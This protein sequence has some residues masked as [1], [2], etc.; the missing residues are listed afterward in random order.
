MR[1]AG[2]IAQVGDD[3]GQ[4]RGDDSEQGSEQPTVVGAGDAAPS[5]A[6]RISKG[7]AIGRYVVLELIGHGGMGR[8]YKAYDPK[9]KREVALKL[10]RTNDAEMEQRAI[11]EAQ[12]MASLS[13]PNVVPVYDVDRADT[14]IY[15]AMEFIPGQT[16][17]A[18]LKTV[19]PSQR[20][21]AA[22]LDI[23][24]QVGRGLAAAHQAD[25]VHRDLKPSNVVLGD[26]GRARVM[27]FGLAR[28]GGVE[29]DTGDFSGESID[30]TGPLTRMGTVLGTPP[31]MPPEQHRA[32]AV[33]TRSDQFA[34]CVV[35]YEALFG[36]RPF[37]ADKLEALAQLKERGLSQWPT[38]PPVPAWLAKAIRKGLSPR[39][40]GRFPS[41]DA[42][43][44]AIDR[45]SGSKV[46]RGPV[47]LAGLAASVG[48]G[49]LAW[50]QAA[51]PK[52][53]DPCT[54]AAEM[55]AGLWN[56]DER[57][58]VTTRLE[59]AALPF[60]ADTASRV[61][62]MLDAYS[63]S[64]AAGRYDACAATQIRHEQSEALMDRRFACLERA[65][66]ALRST[67]HELSTP[68]DVTVVRNAIRTVLGLPKLQHC[69]DPARLLAA[70][71][72][73]EDPAVAA[74]VSAIE[75]R[76]EE[77]RVKRR[78]GH[79]DQ[80]LADARELS[81][82]AERVAYEPVRAEAL[83]LLGHL[84]SKSGE[85]APA[86]ESLQR[87]YHAAIVSGHD[88][89]AAD[90]AAELTFVVGGLMQDHEGAR[91]H[92][93]DSRA[94]AEKVGTDEARARHENIHATLLQQ[95]GHYKEA[96]RRFET[97]LK[98][99]EATS[100]PGSLPIANALNNLANVFMDQGQPERAVTL[101][102]RAVSI[103]ENLYGPEHVTVGAFVNNLANAKAGQ[104]L[105]DEGWPLYERALSIFE[106]TY[107]PQHPDV[108]GFNVNMA[109]TAWRRGRLDEA[110]ARYAKALAIQRI[111]LEP[112]HP[113]L[114]QTLS[115][116]GLL[117]LERDQL[118]AAAELLEE[119]LR[120]NESAYAQDH[121]NIAQSLE[122]V[123]LI[124]LER[125][126]FDAAVGRLERAAR[127][128]ATTESTDAQRASGD[129]I[130]A[131]ALWGQ[132]QRP[133]AR[134]A[135]EAALRRVPDD[136]E[137]TPQVRSWLDEHRL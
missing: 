90:A 18:W 82:S 100:D 24:I 19:D 121:P 75:A 48:I 113:K 87:A 99:R 2:T 53:E 65:G 108:A 63:E 120:I 66:V 25:L 64:L 128:R 34:Y 59:G 49:A 39:A 46:R 12:A 47:V 86:R 30:A 85:Y 91:T 136:D 137:F 4:S 40:A 37:K 21:V 106:R 44:S 45:G 125:D 111:V 13:H 62:T 78:A 14:R 117:Q 35:F 57:S 55:T 61:A 118:G 8:V 92:V 10:L 104:G 94:W 70:L 23:M 58:T 69:S 41:M 60:A 130:L 73:P 42:L 71:P 101:Y 74:E 109:G 79:H 98:L 132:G 1:R 43:L 51:P 77:A 133:R 11:R 68:D 84:L 5:S 127:I 28:G 20:T 122:Q 80:A 52:T 135:A 54:Q 107:G 105:L 38:E 89:V 32:G 119:A 16:L 129:F 56:E 50:S 102:A 6:A 9:L 93:Q 3:S 7:D 17:R 22:V 126:E 103:G 31:Y 72:R 97:A 116:Y 33:D 36:A 115:S 131:R 83:Y 27:D 95:Q 81:R 124:D 15:I 29:T 76:L 67:V 88:A 123:A 96:Q 110:D 112:E 134:D 26:D 114:A